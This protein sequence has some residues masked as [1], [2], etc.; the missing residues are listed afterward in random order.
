MSEFVPPSNQATAL[1][2][3]KP[4]VSTWFQDVFAAPT[5]VQTA[6]WNA[7]S[8]GEHALVVAPTG[9]GKTLA[10]F[11]WAINSL[12]TGDG[13]MALPVSNTTAS[14]AKRKPSGVKVLYISPLKA[15][16]VDVENNLR[17]PLVGINH[18]AA[19]LGVA[20]SEI[21]V[22]VRSG[23]TTS[24]QRA[25]QLRNPPDI[26]ITT[27]ESAYLMLTSKAAGILTDVH[28]VIIDE[29]HALAGTKRGVHLALSL[30]RLDLIV[31]KP[32]QRI[33]LSATVRPLEVVAQFLGGDRPVE[34][35]NPPAEKRWDLEVNVPVA[36][37]SDL[38]G[39]ELGATT[40]EVIFDD[41]L[42]LATPLQKEEQPE[43]PY[44]QYQSE[45]AAIAH[46]PSL[47]TDGDTSRGSIWP[48]IE[49]SLFDEI[50]AHR[51]T[52]VFVNSRR[53]AERLTARLNEIYTLSID[54][55]SLTTPQQLTSPAQ[56][57]A[58]ADTLKDPSHII[59]RAHHGSV[60]K[61]E[62]AK[63][64]AML[65]EG[66][67][68][69][70]VAT[71]SLELGIDMGAVD[72][73]VQVEAPPSVAAG[74]Q[75][76][77]RAGHDVG[78]ISTGIFYPKHRA[79]LVDTAVVVRQMRAGAIEKLSVPRNA[80]D[81]L[82]QQTIAAVSV[83][84]LDVEH[85]YATV[86]RAY[87]YRTLSREVFDSVIDLASGVYP[88]TDFADLKPRITFDRLTGTLSAR[89][90]AQRVAVT[91]GGTIPDRGLFG[92]Y[93]VGGEAG[94][95]RVGELDEE[96]VYESRVGDVFTLGASS[97]RIEEITRDQVLVSPAPGHA[98]RLPFWSGDQVGR[99]AELGEAIGEF[100]RAVA[101]SPAEAVAMVDRLNDHAQDNLVRFIV[102]QQEATGVVPDEKTLVLERFRDEVG[103][104]R[105]VLHSPFGRGV[106]AAWALAV[107]AKISEETGVDGQ[108]VSADDGIV[109]RL[110]ES[111]HI[112]GAELFDI[113]P[114]EISDIVAS[115]V[116]NSALF[117]SRFRECA[118][119][120]LLLPRK[121]PGKRAP[122]WQQRQ[123]ASQ[124]LD[125]AKKYPKFPIILE[126]V[127]ECIQDVYDVPA[128][129][130][131]LKGLRASRITITAVTTDQPS[132]FASAIMFN[133]TGAFMYQGDSPLAE[134]RAAALALDPSL[135]A[136]LL[137]SEGLRDLL[138]PEI[139]ADVDAQLR[140]VS[141]DRRARDNEE[142]I[143]VL[144][145]VGPIRVDK[146]DEHVRYDVDLIKLLA[147]SRVMRVR[148]AGTEHIAQSVDAALLR[149]GLG[150]PVPAG[151]FAQVET[152][153]DAVSQLVSRWLR[154][155]G[156]VTLHDVCAAFG[157]PAGVAHSTLTALCS[158]G[159]AQQGQYRHG[160]TE[161]EYVAT[162]VLKLIRSK[163]LAAARAQAQPVSHA[164]YAR[165]LA[166]WQHVAPVGQT[167]KLGGAD[168]V[169]QVIEQ[170][171]GTALP[172]SAWEEVILP[173]RVRN[174]NPADLDELTHNGEVIIVGCG[175]AG[176]AD[177]WVK[178]L[179][180]EFAAELVD[181]PEPN[182]NGRVLSGIQQQI[183]SHIGAGG[184]HLYSAIQ[185]M[186]AADGYSETQ[187]KEAMWGLFETGAISPD[188]FAPLR[189]RLASGA[190]T[191]HRA[192]RKPNRSRGRSFRR[193]GAGFRQVQA[194]AAHSCPPD[195]VGRWSATT[196]AETDA[197]RRSLVQA[198]CWLERYGV[199]TRGAVTAEEVAGGFALAYKVLSR[200][201]EAGRAMRGHFIEDLGAAQFST[202]AVIDRLRALSDS[203]DVS[204]WP[205]GATEPDSYVLAACDP[206]NPYGAAVPWPI[207]GPNRAAGALVIL[208]DGVAI[209][210]LTRGG[211]NL[212][213]F[214][215]PTGVTDTIPVIV[216]AL[217]AQVSTRVTIEKINGEPSL[218]AVFAD[219]FRSAGANITPR[220]ITINPVVRGI[221]KTRGR[222]LSEALAELPEET[223]SRSSHSSQ[224][225]NPYR[226]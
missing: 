54:P 103:D 184:A 118:A 82:L 20:P 99:P 214:P 78:A 69:A 191:A 4:E 85:W 126:T 215:P 42:G 158:A 223:E 53:S 198:E 71:S 194:A 170:L 188:S 172:A 127:R 148:I 113:D 38:P 2:R 31:E 142:L 200:F 130:A 98:G 111:E 144:R 166:E 18:T 168:G 21:T 167:P 182:D 204:G 125:V 208:T 65:K 22:G 50:M 49:A 181:I 147:T 48:Y 196:S 52:L 203:P 131:V 220:G 15:L 153:S 161:T 156:P 157:L 91:S 67:L 159:V 6:A 150:I 60:S 222:S 141:P 216:S 70:V 88:S 183:L 83:A 37:M 108:P 152:I 160:I 25:A 116:G 119:R 226:K 93:L 133:Y 187:L 61:T 225:M 117:A 163:S 73:V 81:V 57:M 197:T 140:R 139:I 90:G 62:R 206:A 207:T 47:A 219:A 16:G 179:P 145:V 138:D 175:I 27:P 51:S 89:P 30:E 14:A 36:D 72:L 59:A 109:L 92:V 9:S 132:P 221:E 63:T 110:P 74:L 177:P 193:M 24:A 176:A 64:E 87:P 66:S 165:F 210:H 46:L 41:S 190:N 55:E 86:T 77:G 97:W 76:V 189:A 13:Q 209:A 56:V 217:K 75:R 201:E 164:T 58:Q 129:T 32:V 102:E 33:G 143:D 23:D 26:L 45:T 162:D 134:K 155:R 94:A 195:M 185:A 173:A 178:L 124:L 211:K 122:L 35:I 212:T 224:W 136:Q 80:L 95:R 199:V 128:L 115:Q 79:D 146:L 68:K 11:L 154:S 205:S 107:G 120:A 213:I 17:A 112:P 105:I 192:K 114:A 121:N 104:W 106:N 101:Q 137:G 218:N 96:M 34:I 39:P 174:Y 169:Y 8:A 44:V 100:R 151:V 43:K 1:A 149:D 171:A 7:I 135:L 40:S 12:V 84:D 28:T 19:R 186:V 5:S 10:A 29:I 180:T 202:P 3:F 123:R